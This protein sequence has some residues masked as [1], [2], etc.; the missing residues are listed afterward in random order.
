MIM[1]KNRAS[2]AAKRSIGLSMMVLSA[3]LLAGTLVVASASL[4]LKSAHAQNALSD[5]DALVVMVNIERIRAQLLLTERSL[6]EA[7]Q[8][9]AF[10]HAF[11][12]HTATFPAI[13]NHLRNVHEQSATQLEAM[14]TDLP[15]KIKTGE[16]SGEQAKEEIG[17]INDML[18]E[19]SSLV[20]G[21]QLIQDK[22]MLSQTVVFLLRDSVQSYQL[23][24]PAEDDKFSQVD[25]ENAVGLIQ[26]AK[27]NYQKISSSLD[28]RRSTEINSFFEE[29]ER[30]LTQERGIENVSRLVSAIERDLAEELSLSS[31]STSAG[32]HQ[33]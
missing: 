24:N 12:P 25:Y 26:V 33:E 17:R 8:D 3:L 32:E 31:G 21:S 20:I 1:V 11:I 27:G 9:M 19:I 14:L 10:A 29:L 23:A 18:D 28:Q 13:K 15:I 4:P 6:A 30:S 5:T 22:G 7:N 2:Y 16:Y